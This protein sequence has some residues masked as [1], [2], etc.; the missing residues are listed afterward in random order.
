M[1]GYAIRALG[2]TSQFR[3]TFVKVL[4]A[5]VLVTATVET[6]FAQVMV[7]APHPDDEALFASGIIHSAVLA[8]KNVKVVILTNG[9]C[10]SHDIGPTRQQETV[11]AMTRLGLSANDVI[12][13]EQHFPADV[14]HEGALRSVQANDA[15]LARRRQRL[16]VG[17]KE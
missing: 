9:D 3:A 17:V 6:S 11:T 8:G 2:I 1:V 7:I 4:L 16:A 5:A 12:F 13:L 10:D 15:A 14:E